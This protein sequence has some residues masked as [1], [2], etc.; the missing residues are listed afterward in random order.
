MALKNIPDHISRLKA[1]VPGKPI[2][3]V[4]RE[5]NLS[6]VIKL[7]SNE[8]PLGASP[9]AVE[10]LRSA[11]NNIMTYPEGDAPALRTAVAHHVNV[12]EQNIVFG[13]GSDELLHIL[14]SS[15]LEPGDGTVQADPSFAMYELYAQQCNAEVVK[16]PLLAYTHDLSKMADAI[17]EK[18]RLVFIANPNNPTGTSVASS[19]IENY[20]SRVPDHVITVFDQAYD[21]YVD[22]Q[23]ACDTI[24]YVNEG[25]NVVVLKTFSKAYGL[26]GLRV[27]YAITTREIADVMN[28]VR[29]PFNV[30]IAAQAAATAAIQDQSHIRHSVNLNNAGKTYLYTEFSVLGL[31]YV[32]TQANF[33][34]VNVQS[35]SLG[36]FLDMQRLGVIV[37]AGS[38]LGLPKHI[39]VTIGTREQNERFI[40]ALSQVLTSKRPELDNQT[41]GAEELVSQ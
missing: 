10:A 26:A 32:P 35:D 15:F 16:I 40:A 36:V 5:F 13:N 37:R 28:R 8:N 38:G 20:M 27:G 29:S 41:T 11:A 17:T 6:D 4:K 33:V 22:P 7:A 24:K 19:D 3:Q 21:E 23:C 30:N 39:R 31:D 12:P 1:Y 9:F 18:T 14:A 34:L 2:D 25:K